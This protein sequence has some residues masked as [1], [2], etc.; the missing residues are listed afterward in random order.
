[1]ALR[2]AGLSS[3]EPCAPAPEAA[4]LRETCTAVPSALS[5]H[6]LDALLSW[7]L[8]AAPAEV[9]HKYSKVL[10]GICEERCAA[11]PLGALERL[12]DAAWALMHP[13]KAAAAA[14]AATEGGGGG[15]GSGAPA[16]GA[17]HAQA[18]RAFF[19]APPA[20]NFPDVRLSHHV[21]V[22]GAQHKSGER[23]PP[24]GAAAA[25]PPPSTTPA[26]PPL[27]PLPPP[28]DPTAPLPPC[29]LHT[30]LTLAITLR[31][32]GRVTA[33]VSARPLQSLAERGG[34]F[35]SASPPSLVLKRGDTGTL[36]L[37]VTLLHPGAAVGALV[38]VEVA[39]KGERE[40]GLRQCVAV[41]AA[42]GPAVF[43]VPLADVPLAPPGSEG[44]AGRSGVPLPLALLRARL[45]RLGGLR[46]EGVFRVAPSAEERENLRAQ[47]DAG[48][49]RGAA[50][51]CTGVAAA[52][53]VKL[54]LRE[55]PRPVLAAVPTE[56]LLKAPAT[57][58][59]T[60]AV[61]A[62]LDARSAALLDWLAD[63]LVE[64]A[65]HEA[66]NKMGH[67]NLAI[68]VG[69]NLFAADETANP[70]EALMTMQKAVGLLF[71]VLAAHAAG[72]PL[73]GGVMQASS[74]ASPPAAV[75]G[76]AAGG[77]GGGSGGAAAAAAAAAER[78]PPKPAPA[79]RD[80][81]GN[82]SDSDVVADFAA[83]GGG[84]RSSGTGG[85]SWRGAAED[86]GSN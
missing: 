5:P 44:T 54:F 83:L 31:N 82:G 26:A 61:L 33:V 77:G 3:L 29:P 39:A 14:A 43:G 25:R 48:T 63:L 84:K 52:H 76:E 74:A 50:S 23:V 20:P 47:L 8:S 9:G 7:M 13:A 79:G 16:A 28:A 35:V 55:L 22:F 56:E 69:P 32:A 18:M 24:V 73:V 85:S 40:G 66:V 1:M 46:E 57:D 11:R 62:R 30:P 53:M 64:T 34:A 21:V 12:R 19:S 49:F 70:M 81:E 59:A 75:A 4:L 15:G 17:P 58:A 41:R 67:Q 10:D 51:A 37:H 36:C 45:Q 65:Q 42:A 80:G 78:S 38:V 60:A 2:S 6:T 68:C 86:G 27:P 71:R 72:A